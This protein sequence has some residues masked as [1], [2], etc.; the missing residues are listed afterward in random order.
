M[1]VEPA[2]DYLWHYVVRDKGQC[3]PVAVGDEV[4]EVQLPPD[5]A[6]R[7]VHLNLA[8][9]RSHWWLDAQPG[10]SPRAREFLY[11]S[12]HHARV[13][14][15]DGA[16][17]CLLHAFRRDAADADEPIRAGLAVLLCEEL[18]ITA[19]H[20]PLQA[21]AELIDRVQAGEVFPTTAA[22]FEAL[23][24]S[25]AATVDARVRALSTEVE[26]VE[27]RLLANMH[28]QVVH[29]VQPIRRSAVQLHRLLAGLRAQF[30]RI[31]QEADEQKLPPAVAAIAER[32]AQRF[33]GL[34]NDVVTIEQQAR[35][36]REEVDSEEARMTNRNLYFLSVLTGVLLTPTL[37]TGFFGMN[38]GNL[39]FEDGALGT[40]WASLLMLGSIVAILAIMRW[41]GFFRR[42]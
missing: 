31:E 18:I 34:D 1:A 38:T 40:L 8:D 12:G 25:I 23:V 19:R 4:H 10:L 17:L 28:S 29:R 32:L 37:V 16:L 24:G 33:E 2:Q 11:S 9:Q 6:F 35:L 13:E 41:L 21:T 3:L 30:R 7:W 14:V 26:S 36:L 27:D 20:T 22:M 39:P 42:G 5:T 15:I